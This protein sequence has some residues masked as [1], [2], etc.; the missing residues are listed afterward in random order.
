MSEYFLRFRGRVEG[1]LPAGEVISRWRS[2]RVSG[3][4][5]C[6][7]DNANWTPLSRLEVITDDAGR[8]TIA[9]R[10]EMGRLRLDVHP[11]VQA[12][13]QP[14]PLP[15]QGRAAEGLPPVSRRREF[16]DSSGN[17]MA[18]GG[19]VCSIAGLFIGPVAVVG[20][21][22]SAIALAR[23]GLRGLAIAGL[24]I[25]IIGTLAWLVIL[26]LISAGR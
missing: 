3:L 18:I 15:T 16:A 17:G 9:P 13:V 1:P 7:T 25:G 21:I 23:P 11:P 4:H 5:E 6:S 8:E 20:L 2:G 14:P 22:L 24:V 26:M 12:V 19:F 10:T